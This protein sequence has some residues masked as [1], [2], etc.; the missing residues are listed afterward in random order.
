MRLWV[1]CSLKNHRPLKWNHRTESCSKRLEIQPI[2]Q[3]GF[4]TWLGFD[5][6]GNTLPFSAL[7]EINLTYG[8]DDVIRPF[9]SLSFVVGNTTMAHILLGV[10]PAPQGICGSGVISAI[11][12][13]VEAGIIARSGAFMRLSTGSLKNDNGRYHIHADSSETL[14][15]SVISISHE[16]IRAIQLGKAA[17]IAGIE[18]LLASAGLITPE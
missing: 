3:S 13:F 10:N 16:H 11:T 7:D 4:S 15:G 17:L 9:N 12:A 2:P 1:R 8:N 14:S 18:C 6:S 5:R